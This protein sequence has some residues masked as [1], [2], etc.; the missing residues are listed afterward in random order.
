MLRPIMM[1]RL[2]QRCSPCGLLLLIVLAAGPSGCSTMDMVLSGPDD[3]VVAASYTAAGEREMAAGDLDAA[4]RAFQQALEQ[5]PDY[6]DAYLGI[7][8][9]YQ[10]RGNLNAAAE[11]Y[12]DARRLSPGRFETNYK[13]GLTYHLLQRVRDAVDLYLTALTVDPY[14]FEANANLATAY[15]QLDQ[16]EAALPYAER[17]V[18]LNPESQPAYANLGAIYASM[19]RPEDAVIA[20]RNAAD[21]GQLS[22]PIAVNLVN[23]L[24][25]AGRPQRAVN[26]LETLIRTD[27]QPRASYQERLGYAHFKLGNYDQSLQAY[28]H[29]LDLAPDDIA[30]LNGLGVNLMTRYIRNDRGS[31][32]TRDRAIEAW[33]RS[34]RIDAEQPRIIDLIARYRRL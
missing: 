6:T 33:R 20:Y 23:T 10:K 13:L 16:P 5:D 17:A 25:D 3:R 26:T 32:D 15:L 9:V 30:A 2:I 8:D 4:L 18:R 22:P 19:G 34:L 14:N 21:L 11:R 24:L 7:G 12:A 28:Q 31:T 1:V 29:A 27:P